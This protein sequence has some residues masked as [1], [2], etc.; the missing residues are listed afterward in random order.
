MSFAASLSA[1]VLAGV[2]AVAAVAKLLDRAGTRETLAEF[3]LPARVTAPAAVAL[4]LLELAI[5]IALVPAATARAGAIVACVTLLVFTAAIAVTLAR[6]AAPDCN[7]FGGLTRTTVGRGTLVRNVVL[8]AIAA[9]AAAAPTEGAAAWIRDAVAEGRGWVI[10]IVALSAVVLALAWFAWELLRQ[11]GRLLVRLDAQAEE[12]AAGTTYV[13]ALSV[14]D[15]APA[16]ARDDLEGRPLSLQALLAE[17]RPV[18]LVFSDPDCGACHAPLEH[19]ARVQRAGDLTVAIVARGNRERMAER[20]RELGL[21][22]VVHDADD[23]LFGDFG[24][25]GSPGAVLIGADGHIADA[26]VMGAP[27]VT[28][29][30]AGTDAQVELG[31]RRYA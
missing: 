16:F 14:G 15:A 7:C 24:F 9:F 19:A 30:L 21:E 18:A 23:S 8:A 29:L 22:R 4:P 28:E 12:L 5:A 31:V 17:A 13:P 11:N 10:A 20:A 25:A 2:F 27:E 3:G 6:G 1:M 26:P